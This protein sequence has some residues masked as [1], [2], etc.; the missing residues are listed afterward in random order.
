MLTFNASW[1]V[2][3]S[4]DVKFRRVG[5]GTH[6]SLGARLAACLAVAEALAI[7]TLGGLGGGRAAELEELAE[8]EQLHYRG[9]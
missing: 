5:C 2:G 4:A 8:V 1:A 3:G 9:P 7:I 6:P